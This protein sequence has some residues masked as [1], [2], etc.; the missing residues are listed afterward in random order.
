ML[1][2]EGALD[3]E[4]GALLDGERLVLKAVDGTRSGEI[5]G[6]VVAAIDFER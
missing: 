1:D 2:N 6:D 4:A 3:A 5:D